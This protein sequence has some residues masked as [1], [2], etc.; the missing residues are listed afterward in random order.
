VDGALPAAGC[1][2]ARAGATPAAFWWISLVGNVLMLGYALHLRDPVFVLG[3]LPG[4]LIQ[5]RN[6][7]LAQRS[8]PRPA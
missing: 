8:R 1:L 7:V 4:P 3:Y 5:A 6:L 2:S